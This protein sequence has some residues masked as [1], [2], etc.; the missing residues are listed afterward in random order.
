MAQNI[1]S[2]GLNN[3]LFLI[4]CLAKTFRDLVLRIIVSL[5]KEIA[6]S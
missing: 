5:Y 3:D 1:V 2:M 6:V 4:E